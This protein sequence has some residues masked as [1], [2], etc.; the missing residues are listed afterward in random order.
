M[1]DGNYNRNI[2]PYHQYQSGLKAGKAQERTLALRA[3]G[4]WLDEHPELDRETEGK[5]FHELL[6]AEETPRQQAAPGD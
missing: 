3:F 2:L 6:I 1:A 5:R 4:R